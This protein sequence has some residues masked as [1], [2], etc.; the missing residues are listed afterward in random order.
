MLLMST[1]LERLAA[2][3][4]ALSGP[5]APAGNSLLVA[6]RGEELAIP[7][8]AAVIHALGLTE[9]DAFDIR[10]LDSGTLTIALCRTTGRQA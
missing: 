3:L 2:R 1:R 10:A 6:R 5:T 8:P 9:G 7:L 4:E